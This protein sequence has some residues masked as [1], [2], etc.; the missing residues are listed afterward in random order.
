MNETRDAIIELYK[1]F[2]NA[3]NQVLTIYEDLINIKCNFAKN[4]KNIILN[5]IKSVG[6]RAFVIAGFQFLVVIFMGIS[7]LS[8]ILLVHKYNYKK[9]FYKLNDTNDSKNHLNNNI[10]KLNN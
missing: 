3:T 1:A 8:G 2:S 5:E 7:I 10:E 4:D 6:S 9:Q